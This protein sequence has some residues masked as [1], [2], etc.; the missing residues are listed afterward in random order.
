MKLESLQPRVVIIDACTANI[1]SVVNMSRRLGVEPIA[2]ADYRLLLPMCLAAL[3]SGRE[4][5]SD[6]S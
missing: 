4:H 5:G 6:P 2:S 1:G 3:L